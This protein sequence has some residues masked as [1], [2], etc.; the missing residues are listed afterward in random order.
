MDLPLREL[1]PDAV[2]RVAERWRQAGRDKQAVALLERLFVD[3]DRL[4]GRAEAAADTLLNAYLDIGAPRKKASFI[5]ALQAAPDPTLRSCGWQ[6]AATLASDKG[7][8]AR[9]WAA[10]GEA[11]RLT[12]NAPHLSHLE[13]LL[14]VSEGRREEAK[15]RAAFWTARLR[16]DAK[17]DHS[18]LIDLLNSLAAG[19]DEGLMR[20]VQSGRGPLTQL[21]ETLQ[22]WPAPACE[23][24]LDG[25]VEL[26]ASASLARLEGRWLDA[27][28]D[29]DAE[30]LLAL[31]A[32]EPLTGQ[33]FLILRDLSEIAPGLPGGLPGAAE[34]V[35]KRVL[36]RGE[37][38][39]RC[40][41]GEL[42]ALDR[43]LAWGFLDN[44]PLLTL[45]GYYVDAFAVERRD[46][47]LDL[48][49]WSVLTA[50]PTDNVGLRDRLIHDLVAVGCAAEAI[51]V[52]GRYPDDFAST[53]YG[54]VLALFVAGRT[55]DAE[56]ALRTAFAASPKVWKMLHAANPRR[57]RS[58]N[59]GF[60]TVG[61]DDEAFEYRS[62]HLALWRSTGALRWGAGIRLASCPG[63]SPITA[64]GAPPAGR[65]GNLF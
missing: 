28:E 35:S 12:P 48:M 62:H 40:V 25:N 44:R 39:R 60:I 23:Y 32:S 11:Q 45:V 56:A 55:D 54:R 14:L 58:R 18:E 64:P 38:L 37:A 24:R 16:R 36:E 31:A 34:A 15:S 33:S 6:R 26:Q 41:V 9:A 3:I 7:D 61:G 19:S 21:A 17:H 49:R 2:A 27:R 8:F 22:R 4:D 30:A 20:T 42:K 47:V 10:F 59:P 50:N 52:A 1:H 53:E 29:G 57:P 51:A 65:Q 13:V 5:A 63:R 46:E 43:E